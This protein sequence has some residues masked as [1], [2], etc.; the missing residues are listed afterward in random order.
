VLETR[1]DVLVLDS[2]GRILEITDEVPRG[3]IEVRGV[4][5]VEGEVGG[6]IRPVSDDEPNL[7]AMRDVL[8]AIYRQGIEDYVSFI[9]VTNISRI[10]FGYM[11]RFR[12]IL[13]GPTQ[14]NQKLARLPGSVEQI[15]ERSSEYAVGDIDISDPNVAARFT[16]PT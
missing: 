14:L 3:L 15:N 7:E 11:D 4:S 5:A 6:Q 9:D 12:V 2:N 13:G 10:N 8:M 1:I 16:E